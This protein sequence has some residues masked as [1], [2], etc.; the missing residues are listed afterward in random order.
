MAIGLS[1][2][3]APETFAQAN[4]AL[5]GFAAGQGLIGTG[6]QN[7]LMQNQIPQMQAQTGLTQAQIP[8]T[9]M[10]TLTAQAMLPYVGY[11]AM[12]QYYGGLGRM[13]AANPS[14]ALLNAAGK[15]PQLQAMI[16][17][18]PQLAQQVQ[19]AALNVGYMGGSNYLS[20]ILGIPMPGQQPQ[21][22]GQQVPQIGQGAQTPFTTSGNVNVPPGT[23]PG[24]AAG[25]YP[26]NMAPPQSPQ[27]QATQA[28]FGGSLMGG[29][30]TATQPG[31]PYLPPAVPNQNNSNIQD[32]SQNILDN[33]MYSPQQ[34]QQIAFE[35]SANNMFNQL[36]P[37]LPSVA[38]YSGLKGQATLAADKASAALGL[39]T[40]PA[41]QNYLNYQ[42]AALPLKADLSRAL[43][44]RSTD[45]SAEALNELVDPIKYNLTPKQVLGK[46]QQL[47]DTMH[48]N[49]LAITQPIST[50]LNQAVNT[51]TIKVPG[52]PQNAPTSISIPK[53]QNKQQF[54]SWYSNLG[55]DQKQLVKQQLGR[56]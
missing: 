31:S 27:S 47:M 48:Q 17:A 36:K 49:T 26:N 12:G 38:S 41:Y 18:N 11:Q 5:T 40:S 45:A 13:L 28:A 56:T 22:G 1:T 20:N 8:L 16:A 35:N 21:Q 34:K 53:F 25:T 24:A 14:L 50:N 46:W 30:P 23:I 2:S 42:T 54:Q 43:G 52:A 37:T 7:E 4:P 44:E 15:D 55:D 6:I 51:P 33:N 29:A 10:Q 19:N 32:V 3:I 9:N 39:P